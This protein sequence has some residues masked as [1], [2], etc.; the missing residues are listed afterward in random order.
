VRKHAPQDVPHEEKQQADEEV[1][2][3]VR[4]RA[5]IDAPPIDKLPPVDDQMNDQRDAGDARIEVI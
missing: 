1:P 4:P 5:R 2:E 3:L